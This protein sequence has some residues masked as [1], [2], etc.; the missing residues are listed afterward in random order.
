MKP[1]RKP[2]TAPESTAD[3]S[4]NGRYPR[5]PFVCIRAAAVSTP[6]SAI[7]LAFILLCHRVYFGVLLKLD[8]KVIGQTYYRNSG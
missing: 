1:H 6:S 8:Y 5:I 4:R 3:T 2:I 7:R